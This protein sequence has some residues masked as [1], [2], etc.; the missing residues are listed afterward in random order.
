[1]DSAQLALAPVIA[2]GADVAVHLLLSH[3]LP[4]GAQRKAILLAFTVGLAV[5]GYVTLTGLQHGFAPG[6]RL[7]YAVL[8]LAAYWGL[9][10]GYFTF[11][12]LNIASLRIRIL[13]ELLA[14]PRQRLD[15][16]DLLTRY[17]AKAVLEKRLE[18][19]VDGRQLELRNGR[20]H[21]GQSVFLTLARVMDALKWAILGPVAVKR[22]GPD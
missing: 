4:R 18:R 7:A 20:Y 17:D 3:V 15:T 5:L 14:S 9:A 21:S 12:N 11:V 6:D 10:F 1:M 2:A 22:F 13:K 19:L 8:N 16:A